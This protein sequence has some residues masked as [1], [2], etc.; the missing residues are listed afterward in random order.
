MSY[1][2]GKNVL[3]FVFIAIVGLSVTGSA[4]GADWVDTQQTSVEVHHTWVMT[5][6]TNVSL[7]PADMWVEVQATSVE[8][9]GFDQ[10]Q[11][12][13]TDMVWIV[14]FFIPVMILGTKFGGLGLV[15]SLALMSIVFMFGMS[16]FVV[17]G[18]LNMV[19]IIAYM[20]KGGLQ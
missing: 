2:I 6:Q 12:T 11:L 5:Q 15:G 1:N 17:A 20:Y 16:N 4:F 14:V 8:F 9:N 3:I 7:D 10:W 19:G 18:S 13:I